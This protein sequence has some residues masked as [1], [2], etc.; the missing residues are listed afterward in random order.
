[1]CKVQWPEGG[2][3][4][5]WRASLSILAMDPNPRIGTACN[6]RMSWE[7]SDQK[8]QTSR[9][10]TACNSRTCWERSDQ[11]GQTGWLVGW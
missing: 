5:R 11:K 7:R 4:V 8:G 10:G 9:T 3:I 1:M 2:W 6:S